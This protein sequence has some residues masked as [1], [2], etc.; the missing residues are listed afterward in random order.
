M[1]H[2]I[3]EQCFPSPFTISTPIKSDNSRIGL[4]FVFSNI[5]SGNFRLGSFKSN[6]HKNIVNIDIC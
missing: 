4:V 3:W 6:I 5:E 2:E 1:F